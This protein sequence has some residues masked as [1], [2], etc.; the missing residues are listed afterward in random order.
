MCYLASK[1]VDKEGCI[2]RIADKPI[3]VVK[4]MAGEGR[5]YFYAN[6]GIG[7][8][9]EG[10]T[11]TSRI[12]DA[13]AQGDHIAIEEGLYSYDFE[14]VEW[15]TGFDKKVRN[16]I[17]NIIFTAKGS[18]LTIGYPIW[19]W[20][21]GGTSLAYCEVPA[22]SAYY[23][24]RHGV[25]VSDTL[26]VDKIVDLTGKEDIS[27]EDAKRLMDTIFVSTM[28]TKM[29]AAQKAKQEHQQI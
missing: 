8:Y 13:E 9:C 21:C 10:Q 1:E 22:G 14:G 20:K 19:D 7:F 25:I 12:G 5:P 27:T 11:Y 18:G 3:K 26:K 28:A 24:N 29:A 23:M 17:P 2:R 4:V 6:K 15:K 16:L